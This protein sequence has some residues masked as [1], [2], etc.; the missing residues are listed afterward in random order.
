MKQN[1]VS[2]D[3]TSIRMRLKFEPEFAIIRELKIT[4]INMLRALT[5]KEKTRRNRWA[6]KQEKLERMKGKC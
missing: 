3:K 1:K 4:T 2:K 6:M 5:E